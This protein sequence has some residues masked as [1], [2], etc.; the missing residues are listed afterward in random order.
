VRVITI[1]NIYQSL[2]Y[3]VAGK[4][5]AL[6]WY[7]TIQHA[8][9]F[10]TGVALHPRAARNGIV[11]CCLLAVFLSLVTLTLAFDLRTWARFLYIVPN[12]QV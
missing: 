11:F 1:T 7:K 4:Q 3:I 6:K 10:P 2:L 5:L 8:L 9:V 12:R